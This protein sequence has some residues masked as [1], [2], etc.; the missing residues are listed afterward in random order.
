MDDYDTLDRLVKEYLSVFT[1]AY[2]ESY[3]K[4]KHHHLEHLRKYLR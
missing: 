3:Y 1:A 2:P 4:P